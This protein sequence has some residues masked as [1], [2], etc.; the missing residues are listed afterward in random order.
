MDTHGFSKAS[1]MPS[2]SLPM[3]GFVYLTDGELLVETWL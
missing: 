2:A 3:V 1:K